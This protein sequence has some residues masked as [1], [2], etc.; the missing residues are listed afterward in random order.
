MLNTLYGRQR[1]LTNFFCQLGVAAA[2]LGAVAGLGDQL[3][4]ALLAE[5]ATT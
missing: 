4:L 2:H 5:L 1:L 3:D